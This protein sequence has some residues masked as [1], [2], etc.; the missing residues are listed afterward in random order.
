MLDVP[1]LLCSNRSKS[2]AE[3]A[4][5]RLS[6][7]GITCDSERFKH[8]FL[9]DQAGNEVALR[10]RAHECFADPL[11]ILGV[12]IAGDIH[13]DLPALGNECGSMS[14]FSLGVLQGLGNLFRVIANGG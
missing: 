8:D 4:R 11:P 7:A 2:I 6:D 14:M 1:F 5:C 13:A 12:D 10:D 3:T 9:N